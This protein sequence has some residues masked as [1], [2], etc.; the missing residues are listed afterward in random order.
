MGFSGAALVAHDGRPIFRAAYGMAN[1]EFDIPNTPKTKFRIGSVSKQ[2]TAA[3]VLLLAQ[4]DAIAITDPVSKHLPDWPEA[5]SEVTI[6]HLLTHTGGLPRLTTQAM[7]DVSA[8]SRTS[9]LQFE[10]VPDLFQPG[11]DLQPP[12]TK[13]GEQF[14]YS[15]VGYIVLGMIVERVSGTRLSEFLAREI[16]KPLNMEDTGCEDPGVILR[17]RACGYTRTDAGLI[18]AAY[19]DMRFVGG[20]GSVYSTVDDLLL[21]NNALD[22]DHPLQA[23]AKECLF[24]PLKA[25]YACGWWIQ[26]RLDRVVQWHGGNVSGFVAHV[27]RFPADRLFIA[28]LCNVWSDVDR[29]QLRA[30]GNE[31]AAIAFGEKYELPREHKR[32][33]MPP[34]EFEAYVGK[35]SGK[36]TFAIAREG[37]RL[38][39]QWP[40]GVSV[41]ELF[42]ESRVEFFASRPEYYL[43][44]SMDS[45]GKVASARIRNEGEEGTWTRMPP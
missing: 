35:Y 29:G 6:H 13:P 3:A 27:M 28:I 41:F 25:D 17:Q 12:D 33:T 2:F 7:L 9:P 10:E 31:L 42:P 38:M 34:A 19:V 5:W 23:P 14:A 44:F 39:L 30:M 15:N 18:N 36:D 40:P 43:T 45:A 32:T 4:R 21:W 16:F 20:A 11:E 37:D 1:R 8:L 26:K 24:T 22:S